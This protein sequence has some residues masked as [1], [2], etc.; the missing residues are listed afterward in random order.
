MSIWVGLV[1]ASLLVWALKS[2][3]YLVP[4]RLIEGAL[5]SRVAGLVTVALLASLVMSQS[6]HQDGGIVLDARVPAMGVAALLLYFKAPFMV[7]LLAAG[8]VAGGLRF[9]GLMV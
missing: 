9:L 7:V 3:G 5:M 1:V 6:L 4:Q 8:V 2:A